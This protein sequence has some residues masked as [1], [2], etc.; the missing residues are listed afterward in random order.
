M[1]P[2]MIGYI[3]PIWIATPVETQKERH[4]LQYRLTISDR[5]DLEKWPKI[6]Y[7]SYIAIVSFLV[8]NCT[9][10]IDF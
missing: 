8:Y 4:H 1:A 2:D 7:Q 9:K 5:S 3:D 6:V 10:A